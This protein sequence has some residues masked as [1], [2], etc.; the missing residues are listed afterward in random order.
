MEPNRTFVYGTKQRN[1]LENHTSKDATRAKDC[2]HLGHGDDGLS[3]PRESSNTT[4]DAR[5]QRLLTLSGPNM[6]PLHLT[7]A[8]E[9]QEQISTRGIKAMV[10]LSLFLSFPELSSL[11]PKLVV[12]EER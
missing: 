11:S 7:E 4:V 3:Q 6:S 10:W 2:I 1:K 5:T 9:F 12:K 8:Y